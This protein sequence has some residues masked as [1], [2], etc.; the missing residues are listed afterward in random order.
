MTVGHKD[1]M[2]NQ[3]TS[4]GASYSANNFSVI[5]DI[6]H[7][8]LDFFVNHMPIYQKDTKIQEDDTNTAHNEETQ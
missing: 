8:Q 5:T 2:K 3:L 6:V 7:Q 1:R 4:E